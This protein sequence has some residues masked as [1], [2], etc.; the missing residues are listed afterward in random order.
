MEACRRIERIAAGRDDD[1]LMSDDTVRDAILFNVVVIG[2]AA[3]RLPPETQ[4][5]FPTIPW[6]RLRGM[7]NVVAHQYFGLDRDLVLDVVRNKVPELR[8]TLEAALGP[9]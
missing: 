8:R 7:R 2:E 3:T 5:Q 6:P 9:A 1:L 4:A